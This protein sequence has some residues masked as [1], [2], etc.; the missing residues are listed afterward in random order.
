MFVVGEYEK[1]SI[2]SWNHEY[3]A[4]R[5][6]I[7]MPIQYEIN[8]IIYHTIPFSDDFIRFLIDSEEYS[9]ALG[10]PFNIS[11][12]SIKIINSQNNTNNM[13]IACFI[14][15]WKDL[16]EILKKYELRSLSEIKYKIQLNEII[17]YKNSIINITPASDALDKFMPE[18][19]G[20]WGLIDGFDIEIPK[21]RFIFCQ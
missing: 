3:H 14:I 15:M 20:L 5:N 13:C 19:M 10:L 16:K 6:N 21:T 2:G 8:G 12:E 17:P 18:I 1:N 9:F 11:P 4:S 7:W